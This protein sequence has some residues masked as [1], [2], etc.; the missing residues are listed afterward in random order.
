M[1]QIQ[2][3]LQLLAVHKVQQW[4]EKVV[5]VLVAHGNL[6]VNQVVQSLHHKYTHLRLYAK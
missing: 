3:Y 5:E 2:H 4:L 6:L 1:R